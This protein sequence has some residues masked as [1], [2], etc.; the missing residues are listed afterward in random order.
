MSDTKATNVTAVKHNVTRSKRAQILGV[1]VKFRG[2]TIWFT[3]LSGAGKTTLSF[4]VEA[5][6]CQRGIPCYGLDGDNM[7]TGLNK[8][9]GFSPED[10]AENIRRVGEVAKLFADGGIIALA[11]FISPFRADRDSCRKLHEDAGLKFIEC[12]VG[13]PLDVCEARDPKGLYKKARAGIIKGFTGVDGVYEA[14]EKPDITVGTRGESV[15]EN[16]RQVLAYLEE[17]GII[18]NMHPA[19]EELFVPEAEVAA[20]TEEAAALPKLNIDKLTTQWLQVL[21]EGWASPLRGFMREKE[22]LQTIHFNA[23]RKADGSMTNMSVPIVCPATTEEKEQLSSAKAITLVYEGKDLAIMRNP[24]FFEARKEERCARQWGTTEAG[25]PY[26]AQ[27]MAAGDWLVGGDLEVLQ[28]IKWNDG[29]DQYRLTPKELKAE[30]KRRNADAVY[31]F[32]LRN[33][34][35]NGHALLMQDTRRRLIEK[36]FRNPVLLLH[37][38]G[39]WTKADDVPLPTRMKQHECVLN[40]GVLPEESTVVAIF[41]SPMMYAGPT[42]VQWHAKARMNAGA[43]FY[44]VGRDPAGMKHPG[45]EDENLYH[46]DH[47]R[48][49]LQMA[50]GLESLT[51]I[52]FRVA[53]YNKQKGKMDFFDPAK[54]ED[55]EFISGSKMR[56]L[57][58]EGQNP[59]DGFMCPSGWKV[60]STFYQE[61]AKQQAAAQK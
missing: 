28:R 39:G 36:G 4:A 32:Q 43:D 3:G 12:Y 24:E 41:P 8:N 50:P 51:I 54:A 55:F 58:R 16:V 38:L 7:R 6:L 2:C 27:V 23:L 31:A 21:S 60:V 29:L 10:R 25:H 13:T 14:P 47:G 9:L 40:E 46:A 59:P 30:F 22:F 17:E 19:A 52:P 53:A 48:E 45:K 49:V 33:P 35:H 5:E 57:A 20:K 1:D 44:I 56:K 34:V 15:A 61:R 11:S 42:E 37:P 18:P 26:I